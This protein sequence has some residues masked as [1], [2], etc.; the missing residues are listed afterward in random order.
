MTDRLQGSLKSEGKAQ[1]HTSPTAL[2]GSGWDPF[3]VR[4]AFPAWV[5]LQ[6]WGL[7]DSCLS[8]GTAGAAALETF[9]D[10]ATAGQAAQLWLAQ[11]PDPWGKCTSK[12]LEM[13]SDAGLRFSPSKAYTA[14]SSKWVPVLSESFHRYGDESLALDRKLQSDTAGL[15]FQAHAIKYTAN[16]WRAGNLG[17]P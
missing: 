16:S 13:G 15:D 2:L 14:L 10:S 9:L 1:G 6:R 17:S 11:P 5:R 3:P 8:T 12:G 4:P 7:R